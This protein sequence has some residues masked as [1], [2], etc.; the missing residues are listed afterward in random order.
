MARL[1]ESPELAPLFGAGKLDVKSWVTHH[2]GLKD[3][4]K[5]FDMV[6]E[7]KNNVLKAVIKP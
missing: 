1:K 4:H 5:A 2:F 6:A 7:Y 3:A